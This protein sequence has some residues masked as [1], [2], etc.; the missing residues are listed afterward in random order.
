MQ[1]HRSGCNQLNPEAPPVPENDPPGQNQTPTGSPSASGAVPTLTATNLGEFVRYNSCERRFKLDYDHRKLGKNLPFAERLFSSLDPVLTE[2]GQEREDA[3]EDSLTEGGLRPIVAFDRTSRKSTTLDEIAPLLDALPFGTGAY[4]RELAVQ[5][6]IGFFPVSGR[7]DFVVVRWRD[8]RPRVL[9]AECK[10]SRRDRT[11][12]RIQAAIYL[13]IMRALARDGRI[14][15]SGIVVDESEIEAV[16]VRIDE[17]TRAAQSILEAEAFQLD[18]ECA[19]VERLLAEDGLLR[20]IADSELADVPYTIEPKC[21]ACVFNVHCLPWS[22]NRRRLELLGLAPSLIRALR[23]HGIGTIDDLADVDLQGPTAQAL[24]S[25]TGLTEPLERIKA[26]ARVRRTNL[27]TE[28]DPDER[29]YSVE[30]LPHSGYGQLPPHQQN[31]QR[32]VRVFLSIEYDYTE[33]RIGALSAHITKSDGRI[34]TQ[35]RDTA[36][37]R[38]EPDPQVFEQP[39]TG[40]D[41]Y[42]QPTYDGEQPLSGV[43]IV[44]IVQGEWSHNLAADNATEKQ[45][46]SS[47]FGKVVDAIADLADSPQVV[48]HFYVWSKTEI[49]RIVEACA[50]AGSALLS[51]LRE[52]LGCREGL[53]QIIFSSLQDE[54]DSR[55]ALGWTGRGLGVVTSLSWFGRRYHW[56][57]VISGSVVQIDR[58]FTQD[59]FDFK[60]TLDIASDGGFVDLGKGVRKDLYEIRSR[61]SDSLTAPY[62]R[63]YWGTLRERP[64]MNALTR[65]AIKRYNEAA[66]V[67]GQLNAY[68][69]ERVRA[70][71]WVEESIV[72]KN[73]Q[74]TKTPIAVGDLP[75]FSLNVV[76]VGRAGIDFI[77]LDHHVK[78]QNWIAEHLAVPADRIARGRTLPVRNVVDLGGQQLQAMIDAARFGLSLNDLQRRTTFSEDSFVRLSPADEDIDK[79]QNVGAFLYDGKTCNV[80]QIDWTT[81]T[82]V[83]DVV[84]GGF[85]NRYTFRSDYDEAAGA[86][87]MEYGTI[88]ESLSDFVSG[89]VEQRLQSGR[90]AHVL[91]WFDPEN[92]R[93]PQRMPISPSDFAAYDTLLRAFEPERP[94]QFLDDDQR[95]FVVRGLFSTIQ[96]LQGPPGT[97]KTT[98]TAGSV[99]LRALHNCQPGQMIV[100][101]GNTHTAVDTL[102]RRLVRVRD[103]FVQKTAAQ[104]LQPTPVA[105]FK[106]H[107]SQIDNPVGNG[108]IDLSANI[109]QVNRLRAEGQTQVLV[110]GGTP[111][112]LLKWARK[113]EESAAYRTGLPVRHL[114]VDEASMMVLPHFLAVATLAQA[115]AAIFLAGDHRQ[116]DPIVSHDW[117]NEDRPPVLAYQP[118]VSAYQA[119]DAISKLP[120]ITD[121]SVRVNRLSKTYRLPAAVVDLLDRLYSLDNV[122]LHGIDPLRAEAAACSDPFAEIWRQ[123]RGVFLVVHDERR[124]REV[125]PLEAKIVEQIIAAAG[126]AL[127][128][129]S[130]AVITPHRAQRTALKVALASDMQPGGCIRVIDTVEKMQGGECNNICVSG[131]VSD[132]SA[133]AAT[134]DFYLSLN[135]A[136]VAFSRTKERLIVVCASTLL[137]HVPPDQDDYEN[138]LLWKTLREIC[139]RP[140]GEVEI[141]GSRVRVFVP[142]SR[143]QLEELTSV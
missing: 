103:D 127:E 134:P 44:E 56:N 47:F 22:A 99:M 116:L 71:R 46:I 19:D 89:R 36:D 80:T 112:A 9:L 24:R 3:W 49:K 45:L 121:K 70:L 17:L 43:D 83:M 104:R 25:S 72:R 125:N 141:D 143:S 18:L 111:S 84:V 107:S 14:R 27:T 50:R 30:Q 42:G 138:A 38:R 102:L 93:V 98:T 101:T 12:Q 61:F 68:L 81:G 4:I 63:A 119:I 15:V 136:N 133:I 65:A 137:D 85:N 88:D 92:P 48:P 118:F 78:V 97:G 23:E 79:A 8:G 105:V 95:E 100:I 139:S 122:R 5:A 117:D 86:Q 7:I 75:R 13:L 110:I 77:Q 131:T 39:R 74:L 51:S 40:Q 1:L 34:H 142:A 140:I 64:G 135:R 76:D 91:T 41:E 21:D 96:L 35:W 67:F 53:E 130:L 115:D 73:R 94:G 62:W 60:T 55:F 108:I 128:P 129:E 82:I 109:A 26:L 132:P 113:A 54:V 20:S 28:S 114:V 6:T 16:V 124:S 37:G 52:L 126:G 106:L 59:I 87:L 29:T 120:S 123:P 31:A 10:A 90:G 58:V 69:R 33:D 32:L 2:A 66:G 11:F 57:R